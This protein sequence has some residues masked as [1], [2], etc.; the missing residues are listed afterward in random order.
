MLQ[1]ATR[2]KYIYT[3]IYNLEKRNSKDNCFNHIAFHSQLDFQLLI[4]I[5]LTIDICGD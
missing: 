5:N 1:E 4:S 3:Y 2:G